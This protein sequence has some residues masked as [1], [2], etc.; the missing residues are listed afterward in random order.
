MES[1][2]EVRAEGGGIGPE[3]HHPGNPASRM[4]ALEKVL[5]PFQGGL[6]MS[7]TSAKPFRRASV[8]VFLV[9]GY[10]DGYLSIPWDLGLKGTPLLG[11]ENGMGPSEGLAPMNLPR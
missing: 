9:S 2:Q 3:A 10:G 11:Q 7:S 8:G 6:K 5:D 1:P 4:P